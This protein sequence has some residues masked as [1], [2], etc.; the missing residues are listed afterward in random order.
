MK[1]TNQKIFRKIFSTATALS[2]LFLASANANQP[3]LIVY[4]GKGQSPEQQ[5]Q[6]ESA[7]RQWAMEQTCHDPSQ[8]PLP[9]VQMKTSVGGQLAKGAIGGALLG[10]GVGAIAGDAGVGAA[11][12]AGA[13][14][15]ALGV[16]ES[17]S[18]KQRDAEYQQYL[19]RYNSEVAKYNKAQ[20]ACLEGR[21]YSVK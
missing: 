3:N 18:Q 19:A 20:K 21:G 13:G 8:Q 1:N 2:F 16:K 10:A 14:G 6:D 17:K 11:I 9:Q 15:T 5:K 12:G 7:C 4:P